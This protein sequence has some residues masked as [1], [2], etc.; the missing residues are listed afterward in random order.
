MSPPPSADSLQRLDALVQTASAL[1]AQLQSALSEIQKDPSQGPP[2]PSDASAANPPDALALAHDS[3]SL[4]RAQGTKVSLLIINE[5]LTPSAICSVVG[6][7]VSGPVP[8]IVSAAQICHP[9][10]YSVV[11]RR[12]LA[13]LSRRVLAELNELLKKI[14]KDGKVLSGLAHAGSDSGKKGSI[15]V[16][17]ILWS[18]CDDLIKLT[19]MGAGGLLAEK[20]RQWGDMLKDISE[21]LKE[22]G[23]ESSEDGDDGS[24]EDDDV[25]DLVGQLGD[26]HV[27]A[28]DMIDD[29]MNSHSSIP[30]HDPD[31]IRPRLDAT[32][33]RLRLVALLYEAARARRFSKLPALPPAAAGSDV[34]SRLDELARLLQRLPERFEDLAGAFY[35]LQPADIDAAMDQCLVDAV[36]AGELLANDWNGAA[37]AFTQWIT[38]F[39]AEMKMPDGL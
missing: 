17:G 23:E 19:K 37:D 25:D 1:L 3:A 30:R 7:L 28:Q 33:K 32:L 8:A 16:T 21:E 20:T 26:A 29:L 18:A 24:G 13:L 34:P 39:R 35:E 22:W 15:Q 36:A 14:P 9:A 12:E 5:P 31:R 11:L 4:I 6:E 38:R 10:Q 27:S 2:A